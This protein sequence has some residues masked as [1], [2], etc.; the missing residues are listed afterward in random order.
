MLR[1]MRTFVCDD[2]GHKFNG[3]DF[4]WNG[5]AMSQPLR[6]P[7]CGSWHTRP[8]CLLGLNKG[9]YVKIWK[10]TDEIHNA[11]NKK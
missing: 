2:C 8:N 11:D 9:Q 5:T 7:K 6:C 3:M 4:E 10:Q 1:G